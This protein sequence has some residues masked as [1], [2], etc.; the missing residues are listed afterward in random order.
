MK[1]S[2]TPSILVILLPRVSGKHTKVSSEINK[3][4]TAVFPSD[5]VLDWIIASGVEDALIFTHHPMIWDTS[6]EG[7]PFRNIPA[8][9]LDVLKE[10][11]ISMYTI[12]VPLDRNGPYSTT[13]SFA[14]A[15][16]IEADREFFDYFGSKVGIIGKTECTSYFEL[17]TKVKDAVGHLPKIY[18]NITDQKFNHKVGVVAGGGNYP[19]VVEEL[20]ETDVKFYITGVTRKKADYEPSLRFHEI[21]QKNKIISMF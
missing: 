4:Y 17:S 9:Y 18:V 21:C 13:V 6:L 15:L 16:E 11:R 12:H 10:N 14:R 5:P 8:R 1:G 7:F 3:V 2:G 20:A 19:E